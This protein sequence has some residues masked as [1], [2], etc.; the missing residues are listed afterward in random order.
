MRKLKLHTETLMNLVQELSLVSWSLKAKVDAGY[1]MP[2]FGF[3]NFNNDGRYT[4]EHT[5][6]IERIGS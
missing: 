1:I 5:N 3:V 6:K 4:Q 2:C